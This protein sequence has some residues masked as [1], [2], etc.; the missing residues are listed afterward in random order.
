M[1]I[2]IIYKLSSPSGKLYIGQTWDYQARMNQYNHNLAEGQPKLN[3]AFKKYGIEN[4][5]KEILDYCYSQEEMDECEIYWIKF[6]NSIKEGYNVREGGSCGKFGDST[7]KLMSEN[8]W[9][10]NGKCNDEYRKKMSEICKGEKNGFYG[11]QH[12]QETKDYLRKLFKGKKLPQS[13]IE[14]IRKG[15]IGLKRSEEHKN[16]LSKA[17]SKYTYEVTFTDGTK[18]IF[19]SLAKFCKENN[20]ISAGFWKVIK[21]KSKTYKGMTIKIVK[22]E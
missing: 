3:N 5:E 4:F 19:N 2:G 18:T 1:S 6:Y 11:K 14:N 22:P 8:N 9:L 21:G 16:N 12:T 15:H 10:K 13:Q 17:N 20:F 7:K